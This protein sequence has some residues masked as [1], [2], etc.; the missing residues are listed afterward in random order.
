[1]LRG[2]GGARAGPARLHLVVATQLEPRLAHLAQMPG[3]PLSQR[4]RKQLDAS[5]DSPLLKA[6]GRT[7]GNPVRSSPH[8]STAPCCADLSVH[9][10]YRDQTTTPTASST[11]ASQR[12]CVHAPPLLLPPDEAVLTPRRTLLLRRACFTTGSPSSG[13][14]RAPSSSSTRCVVAPLSLLLL[15][16]LLLSSP[17]SRLPL[18]CADSSALLQDLTY[19]KSIFG[20][21]RIFAALGQL[22]ETYFQPHEPVTPAHIVTS[23]GLSPLISR[24]AAATSDVGDEWLIPAPWVRP[25]CPS[26]SRDRLLERTLTAVPGSARLTHLCLPLAVQRVQAGPRGDEPSRHRQRSSTR[27]RARHDR[28][29]R[30]ARRGDAAPPGRQLGAE[31]HCS[32]PH[33]SSQ[34]ARCV[35]ALALA[36]SSRTALTLLVLARR[37]LLLSRRPSR[38]LQVRRAVEPVPRRRRDLRP[39]GVRRRCAGL[40]SRSRRSLDESAS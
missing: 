28:R 36:H 26:L 29:G 4:A 12:T 14:A 39:V 10:R 31:S 15:L 8:L 23:N 11:P 7:F 6:L 32:P 17:L 38:V 19:G 2:E 37:F 21:D 20:S 1:L 40:F 27:R 22:Y 5:A 35:L 3:P 13:S 18:P 16:L 25:C 33:L 24:L 9:T 34:P 30:G